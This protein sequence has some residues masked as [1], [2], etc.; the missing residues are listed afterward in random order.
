MDLSRNEIKKRVRFRFVYGSGHL[1]CSHNHP[2]NSWSTHLAWLKL[3]LLKKRIVKSYKQACKHCHNYCSPHIRREELARM[4]EVA[5]RIT[6]SVL[7]GNYGCQGQSP[8][9]AGERPHQEGLCERC[10]EKGSPCRISRK[11]RR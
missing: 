5:V 2:S 7:N 1:K 3:D 8:F 4:I 6:A 11:R 10:E 9:E